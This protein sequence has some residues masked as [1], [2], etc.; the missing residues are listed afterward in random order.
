VSLCRP[1]VQTSS[2]LCFVLGGGVVAPRGYSGSHQGL[3]LCNTSMR[4]DALSIPLVIKKIIRNKKINHHMS[5]QTHLEIFEND[6][7]MFVTLGENNAYCDSHIL[8]LPWCPN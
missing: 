7:Q 1:Q 5:M 4:A 2:Y 3:T 6:R 8:D